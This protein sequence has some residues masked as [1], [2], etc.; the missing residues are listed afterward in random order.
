M[1]LRTRRTNRWMYRQL[2]ERTN[3]HTWYYM[4]MM[5]S[6]GVNTWQPQGRSQKNVGWED[7]DV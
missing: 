4:N 3:V 6:G 5:D 2:S 1:N 7:G